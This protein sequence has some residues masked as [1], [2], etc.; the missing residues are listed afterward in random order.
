MKY[1]KSD[2]PLSYRRNKYPSTMHDATLEIVTSALN[3]LSLFTKIPKSRPSAHL[4][5]FEKGTIYDP[6]ITV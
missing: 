1:S 6:C 5:D 4:P 3:S 2:I